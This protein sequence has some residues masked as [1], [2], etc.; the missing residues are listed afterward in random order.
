[1]FHRIT[2]GKKFRGMGTKG[3]IKG[4]DY[5]TETSKN[6]KLIKSP[7]KPGTKNGREKRV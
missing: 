3:I 7:M 1:M 5:D 2:P 4:N 6:V